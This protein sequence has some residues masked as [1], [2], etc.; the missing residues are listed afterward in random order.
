MREKAFFFGK[1]GALFG[2]S[3]EPDPAAGPAGERPTVLLLNAGVVHH[4]GPHRQSVAIARRL[5]AEG[6][7]VMRFDLAGLGESEPRRDALPFE[8]GAVSD[9]KE[10]M[11]HLEKTRGASRFVLMGL[12]SG[13]DT[14]F[15]TACEDARVV[16][17][18]LIDGY[19]YPTPE[20]HARRVLHRARR[21]RSWR[22]VAA[23]RLGRAWQTAQR[24][25]SRRAA[26]PTAPAPSAGP[27]RQYLREF[28]PKERFVADVMRL[29]Q[30]G[31]RL[32]FVY[33]FGM[34]E[35]YN[36]EG[37]ILAAFVG[38]DLRG[39]VTTEL[40]PSANHTFTA[41]SNQEALVGS[42]ASWAARSFRAE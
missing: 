22:A 14:S 13:A 38:H 29:V 23:R 39:R 30:R 6:F 37:Q 36:H 27:I 11:D 35:Y 15:L 18:V 4:I 26:E 20:F 19:A 41:L 9:V 7:P 34:P 17:A 42:I 1:H 5:A 33:S 10:A 3:T 24:V 16:G 25:A 32:H 40:F 28:P 12:C 2:V 8:A 21:V 31:V